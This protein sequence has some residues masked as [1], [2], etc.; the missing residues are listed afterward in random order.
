MDYFRVRKLSLSFSSKGN[1]ESFLTILP[2]VV[3]FLISLQLLFLSMN[4]NIGGY[5]DQKKIS[6]SAIQ[7]SKGGNEDYE[8][9]S[10]IGGGELLIRNREVN[11]QNLL[12]FFWPSKVKLLSIVVD[13]SSIQ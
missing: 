9:L 7:R 3:I 5:L 6:E 8:R 1:V 11:Q 4:R 10:M 2:Q 12:S 13:E